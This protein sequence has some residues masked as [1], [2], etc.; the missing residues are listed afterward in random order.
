M[1]YKQ[2][3]EAYSRIVCCGLTVSTYG[4]DELV[5]FPNLEVTCSLGTLMLHRPGASAS[6]GS[7]LEVQESDVT[8]SP[9]DEYAHSI[10][11]STGPKDIE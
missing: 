11:I 1:F 10:F 9:D 2:D 8:S 5:L 3:F 7:L 4:F 6:P